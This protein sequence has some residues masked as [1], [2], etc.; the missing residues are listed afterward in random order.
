M[1]ALPP[2]MNREEESDKTLRRAWLTRHYSPL[3][4]DHLLTP[5]LQN[6]L[7]RSPSVRLR[8]LDICLFGQRRTSKA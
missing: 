7:H 2:R 1:D 6:E 8:H 5:L 3:G 4:T